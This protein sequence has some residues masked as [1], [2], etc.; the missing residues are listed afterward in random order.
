MIKWKLIEIQE[1]HL[2]ENLKIIK[3]IKAYEM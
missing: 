3:D 2:V 1:I